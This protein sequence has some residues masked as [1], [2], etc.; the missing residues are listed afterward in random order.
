MVYNDKYIT[1]FK[2]IYKLKTGKNI[3]DQEAL[4]YFTYLISLTKVIYQPI[5]NDK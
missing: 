5:I 1:K 4:E 3:T 2:E